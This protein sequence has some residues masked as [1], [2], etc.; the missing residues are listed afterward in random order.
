MEILLLKSSH[1]NIVSFEN[2]ITINAFIWNELSKN[3][4]I[5][6]YNKLIDWLLLCHM[7]WFDLNTKNFGANLCS[8]YQTH[9]HANNPFVHELRIDVSSTMLRISQKIKSHWYWQD[10]QQNCA[11]SLNSLNFRAHRNSSLHDSSIRT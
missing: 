10:G 11:N 5:F 7:I 6:G 9:T 2:S 3:R 1:F 4:S 8:V